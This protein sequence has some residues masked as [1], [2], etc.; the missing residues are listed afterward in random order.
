[1]PPARGSLLILAALA[2]GLPA[3]TT[4][5]TIRGVVTDAS[6]SGAIVMSSVVERT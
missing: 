4:V 3:R 6:K 2:A 1:M 5:G